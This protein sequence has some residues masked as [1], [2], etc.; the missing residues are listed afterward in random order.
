MRVCVREGGWVGG[1]G[2]GR[3]AYVD[4][5]RDGMGKEFGVSF[6]VA[7]RHRVQDSVVIVTLPM[8]AT[9]K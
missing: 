7:P 4:R 8:A 1:V 3:G 5:R 6:V 9:R 2:M